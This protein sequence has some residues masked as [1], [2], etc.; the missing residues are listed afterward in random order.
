MKF[1]LVTLFPDYFS[2]SLRQSLLGKGIESGLFDIDIVNLRDYAV[3]KHRTVD[4]TPFGGGGG[5]VMKVEPLDRCLQALS[6]P[7]R[8]DSSGVAKRHLVLT[9]AAGARFDQEMAV[10]YSLA[11]RLTI[12]CGH[13]LGVDERLLELYEIEEVSIGDFVLTG[14]EPA[15]AVMVDA[16]ARLLPGVLG[17][18][19]SALED[20]YMNQLLGSPCYTRPAEYDGL[21]VPEALLSGD[22]ARIKEFRRRAAIERCLMRRPE[23]LEQADLTDDDLAYIRRLK[24]KDKTTR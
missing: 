17:N 10:R 1:E 21:A 16:V 13:Y 2:L 14:G 20:S 8:G 9:S 19:E 18:F 23:L 4:D 24:E 6:W 7:R 11:E 3:D 15:A 22:H 5:M 12:V